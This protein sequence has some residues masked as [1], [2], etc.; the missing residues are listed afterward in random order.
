[1]SQD[2]YFLFTCALWKRRKEEIN[3]DITGHGKKYETQ[4]YIVYD[5]GEIRDE[6]E[7]KRDIENTGD[8]IRVVI[9]K[10]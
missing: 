5:L 2:L 3:S 4:L 6:V 10:H 8:R 7:F 1:M 9:V